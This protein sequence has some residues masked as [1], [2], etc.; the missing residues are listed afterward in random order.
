[1]EGNPAAGD[2]KKI[3][4][5]FAVLTVPLTMG[6]PKVTE[7]T[8]TSFFFFPT[9]TGLNDSIW[10]IIN[11]KRWKMYMLCVPILLFT[12]KGSSLVFPVCVFMWS[13]SRSVHQ[14]SDAGFNIINTFIYRAGNFL[15]LDYIQL[16]LAHVW[17]RWVLWISRTYFYPI[18]CYTVCQNL[19]SK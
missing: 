12:I 1:M 8:F 7:A 5:I 16:V 10:H 4:R 11:L 15:L 9:L 19:F 14:H 13:L 17:T 3:S 18:I 6:F 2:M